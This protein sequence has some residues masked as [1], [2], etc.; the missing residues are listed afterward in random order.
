MRRPPRGS[1]PLPFIPPM[2]CLPVEN[3]PEGP[4]WVYELKLDGYRA[5]AI[6]DDGGVRLLSRNGKDLTERYPGVVESLRD[7]IRPG[8]VIDG[9]LV[10]LDA[11]GRPSFN[12]LQNAT[13]QTPV[14]LYAFDILMHDGQDVT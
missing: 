10:A 8:T 6:H 11:T 3:L 13:A 9:E 1:H 5:Q 2:E 7:S 4:Q 12:A 14:V